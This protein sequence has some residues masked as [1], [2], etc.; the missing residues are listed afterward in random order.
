MTYYLFTRQLL[1][2]SNMD[3]TKFHSDNS[4]TLT[5]PLIVIFLWLYSYCNLMMYLVTKNHSKRNI[6]GNRKKIFFF[7]NEQKD[8]S[9][10]S[11]H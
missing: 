2:F 5:F 9:R 3:V 7:S 1:A 11:R 6:N 4:F 8:P 10:F